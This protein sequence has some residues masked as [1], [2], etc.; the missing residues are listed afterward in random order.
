VHFEYRYLYLS[1]RYLSFNTGEYFLEIIQSEL[2]VATMFINQ[3]G[4]NEQSL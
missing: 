3:S 4:Q 1:K 2:P